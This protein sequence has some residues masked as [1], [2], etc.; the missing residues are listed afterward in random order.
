MA[1]RW[2]LEHIPALTTKSINPEHLAKDLAV[3]NW[4]LTSTEMSQLDAVVTPAGPDAQAS[5][6]CT[7]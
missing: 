5:F 2:I 7:A 3:I 6:I 1:L 4:N